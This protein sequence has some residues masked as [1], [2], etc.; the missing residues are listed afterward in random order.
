MS[1]GS[2]PSP[3]WLGPWMQRLEVA[4]LSA[5]LLA[6]LASPWLRELSAAGQ[7]LVLAFGV[8][9]LGLPHGAADWRRARSREDASAFALGYLG[10]A[11]LTIWLWATAPLAWLAAFFA[12]S[13]FHFAEDRG[14]IA[15]PSWL[16]GADGLLRGAMPLALPL[17]LWP[18]ESAFL[19]SSLG[20]GGFETIQAALVQIAPFLI[21][22]PVVGLAALA[23]NGARI[24]WL[25]RDSRAAIDA[26]YLVTMPLAAFVL[27]PLLFFVL[28]FC[29]WHSLRNGLTLSAE[30]AG[31]G[32]GGR[33]ALRRFGR[34]AALPTLAPICVCVAVWWA[35][36]A[37]GSA[38]LVTLVFVG[39]SGL[40]VA[41]ILLGGSL[42]A[43]APGPARNVAGARVHDGLPS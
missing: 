32:C 8:G 29:G 39:L 36:S 14:A 11:A 22:L 26:A 16:S 7:G 31:D 37:H 2:S 24:A 23:A 20:V 12:L 41:H 38:Q 27:P 21:A 18:G 10:I 33:T 9:L 5:T 6:I 17:G 43:P 28:H 42:A 4:L 35:R 3:A 1:F 30:M 19:L 25:K 15:L 34:A 13:V 40:A